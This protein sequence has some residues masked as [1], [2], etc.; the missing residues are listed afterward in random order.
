MAKVSAVSR[1][2]L[3]VCTS[4]PQWSV[5]WVTIRLHLYS[6]SQSGDTDMK[7]GENLRWMLLL[8]LACYKLERNKGKEKKNCRQMRGLLQ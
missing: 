5:Q 4:G 3:Q 2:I 7:S 1:H 8:E 6:Q